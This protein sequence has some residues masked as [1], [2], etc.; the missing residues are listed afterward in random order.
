MSRFQRR[1]SLH[2]GADVA[3]TPP[4]APTLS[5]RRSLDLPPLPYIPSLDNVGAGNAQANQP[6]NR[7]KDGRRGEEVEGEEE[8]DN[9][10]DD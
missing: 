8:T 10:D 4:P 9:S 3:S 5:A 6:P 1:V 2:N 7:E